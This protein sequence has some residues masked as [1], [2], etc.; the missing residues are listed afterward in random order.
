L[1]FH[2]A[3][4]TVKP[5]LSN[6]SNSP[7][8]PTWNCTPA[9]LIALLTSGPHPCYL[10][11]GRSGNMISYPTCT[12][13]A[14]SNKTTLHVF[15]PGSLHPVSKDGRWP[16]TLIWGTPIVWASVLLA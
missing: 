1:L 3:F 12:G 6:S 11:A 5:S 7:V 2:S 9:C 15:S 16:S 13:Y 8:V 14:H 4:V 10:H